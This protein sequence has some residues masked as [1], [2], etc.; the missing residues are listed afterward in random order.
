MFEFYKLRQTLRII[1]GLSKA[2]IIKPS[3]R[4]KLFEQSKKIHELG[5]EYSICI[6][7]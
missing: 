1:L 4:R 7:L 6:L 2:M 3:F 5:A